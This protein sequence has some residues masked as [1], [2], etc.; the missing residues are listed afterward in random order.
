MSKSKTKDNSSLSAGLAAGVIVGAFFFILSLI[1]SL[2]LRKRLR[3]RRLSRRGASDTVV[4][5][6]EDAN[7]GDVARPQRPRNVLSYQMA[8]SESAHTEGGP[9]PLTIR[10]IRYRRWTARQGNNGITIDELDLVAPVRS[11]VPGTRGAG[12]DAGSDALSSA[13]ERS[14]LRT[15]DEAVNGDDNSSATSVGVPDMGNLNSKALFKDATDNTCAICL[16][17]MEMNHKTRALPCGHE[18]DAVCIEEWVT[19]ANRCPV[20]SKEPVDSAALARRRN[21]RTSTRRGIDAAITRQRRRRVRGQN[22]LFQLQ[23]E[24]AAQQE[25]DVPSSQDA[26]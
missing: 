18:F 4:A 8:G 17:D 2:V 22:G 11:Y 3:Q 19:K 23:N 5:G 14:S 15:G 9:E 20:C 7:S 12:Y 16:E 6:Q 24:V 10:Q 21:A 25:D 26:Q 13:D 1:F